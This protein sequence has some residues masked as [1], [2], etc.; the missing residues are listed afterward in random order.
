M[1]DCLAA[2]WEGVPSC[3]TWEQKAKYP[4]R[5]TATFIFRYLLSLLLSGR[6]HH[7]LPH[8]VGSSHTT[9]P[10]KSQED[11]LRGTEPWLLLQLVFMDQKWELR[12]QAASP[13]PRLGLL[14]FI[15]SVQTP[16]DLIINK[17]NGLSFLRLLGGFSNT[18][19]LLSQGGHKCKRI[20][21]PDWDSL[22]LE[23]PSGM[24]HFKHFILVLRN[25]RPSKLNLYWLVCIE[26]SI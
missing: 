12:G 22:D 7:P 2:L 1:S 19:F 4:Y 21:S 11:V 16:S 18:L 13:A 8:L 10:S 25:L 15:F 3:N 17:L 24:V 14:T 6:H 9:C 26:N 20:R 23:R 5:L